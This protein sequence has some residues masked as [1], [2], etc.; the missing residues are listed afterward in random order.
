[1]AVLNVRVDD[2]V[3]DQLKSTADDEGVTLSE[4]VRDLLTEATIPVYERAEGL[5]DEEAPE[6]L[7]QIDRQVLTL[8]HRILARVEDPDDDYSDPES[9][10]ERATV[11]EQ[12][13]TGEYYRLIESLSPELSR[14]DSDRVL[15]ILEMFR[16]ITF[17]LEK[18]N[19]D[20][21]AVDDRFARDLQFRGFDHNDRLEG[22][23]SR[24]VR[25]LMDDD[26]W[27]ELKDQAKRHDNG[28]S[29]MPVLDVY[30]RMLTEYRRIM[31][32]RDRRGF[33]PNAFYLSLEE[34]QRLAAAQIH[35]SRRGEGG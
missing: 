3:R 26:R 6:T 28:N 25:F 11:I 5:S 8:L 7:R 9:Q 4:Y 33:D 34:L 18:L 29:H 16:Y 17:S 31:D 30:M 13:F 20:G 12:G 14:R 21:V 1:M 35:P 19:R 2:S 10:L 22:R 24:Y 23:M 15:D 27:E 32:G